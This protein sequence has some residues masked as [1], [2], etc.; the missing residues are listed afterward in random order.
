MAGAKTPKSSSVTGNWRELLYTPDRMKAWI[1]GDISLRELHGISPREMLEM[2]VS[3]Y[4]M[5]GQGRYRE[6]E[7]IFGGL[8]ALDPSESYY[9]T[10]LGAIHLAQEKVDDALRE[11][12][13]A[14]RLNPKDLAACVN[15]GEAH[16]R[17]GNVADAARDFKQ[18]ISLDPQAKDPLTLRARALAAAALETLRVAAAEHGPKKTSRRPEARRAAKKR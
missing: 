14:M 15:R 10:A 17:L 1:R 11:F 16:L 3:G 4:A 18:A 5:Y 9:R 6:A 13:Q 8:S 2:A 12:D 7:V